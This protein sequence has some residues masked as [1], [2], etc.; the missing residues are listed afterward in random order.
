MDSI[1]MGTPFVLAGVLVLLAYPLTAGFRR[2]RAH[3]S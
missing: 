2:A 3:G 1:G